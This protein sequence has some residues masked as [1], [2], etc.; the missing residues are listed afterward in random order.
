[1]EIEGIINTMEK[2]KHS[3]CACGHNRWK[4]IEKGRKWQCR[5]CGNGRVGS[6]V[7]KEIMKEAEPM[8][9]PVLRKLAS[10]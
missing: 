5:G 9:A 10:E 7:M 8:L 1:M 2:T 4:T 3:P 6:E